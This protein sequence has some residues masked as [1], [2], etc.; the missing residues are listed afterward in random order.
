MTIK[1]KMKLKISISSMAKSKWRNVNGENVG[2]NGGCVSKGGASAPESEM[3]ASAGGVEAKMW[4]YGINES[5]ESVLKTRN[6]NGDV[7]A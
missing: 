4:Q 6:I 2:S 7:A 5:G 3:A 1:I